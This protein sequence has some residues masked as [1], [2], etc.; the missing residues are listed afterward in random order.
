MI[1]VAVAHGDAYEEAQVLFSKIKELGNVKETIFT[2]ISP[3][4]VV[5][6]GPGLIGIVV[7]DVI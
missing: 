5:H 7:S 4:L 6:T 1:K 2:Q 3:V